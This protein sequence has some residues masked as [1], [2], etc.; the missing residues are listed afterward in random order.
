MK[1]TQFNDQWNKI[2]AIILITMMLSASL[3]A[4][5]YG[6]YNKYFIPKTNWSNQQQGGDHAN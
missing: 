6:M 2:L 4:I 3:F 1:K 5:G